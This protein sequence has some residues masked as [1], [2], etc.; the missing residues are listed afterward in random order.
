MKTRLPFPRTSRAAALLAVLWLI[1]LLTA[2][3]GTTALLLREDVETASVRRQMFLARMY[4]EMGLAV[5]GHPE[6]RPDDPLLRR[7]VQPGEGYIVTMRGEDGRLNPN[8]LLQREDQQTLLRVFAAWGLK[9][10]EAQLLYACLQDWVDQDPF[11]RSPMSWEQRQYG[12]PGQP[13]NRPFRSVDE[14]ALVHG[15][16]YVERLYPGWRE[17]FSVHSSGV[18]DINE[19]PAEVI[20]ALT[21]ADIKF[22]QDLVARRLGRDGLRNTKDDAPYPDVASALTLL[23]VSTGN[24]QALSNVLGVQSSITRV[25]SV[26]KVGD[27]SRTI[28]AVLNRT[29]SPITNGAPGTAPPPGGAVGGGGGAS[30]ILYLGESD[31]RPGNRAEAQ[32]AKQSPANQQQQ[33]RRR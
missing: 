7:E 32:F 27:F 19:A 10:Q 29:M 2:L 17:W 9:L 1:A 24:S 33:G 4:A 16:D 31:T 13:F 22:A 28:F 26:G 14:M 18:V 3:V 12:V 8:V 30:T 5:A 23:H 25:E 20:V 21:G 15:M 11:T 6:V